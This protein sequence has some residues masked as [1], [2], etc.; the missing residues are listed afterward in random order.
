MYSRVLIVGGDVPSP[1]LPALRRLLSAEADVALG[2]ASDGGY[3]AIACRRTHPAMFDGVAWSSGS[4]LRHTVEACQRAG[5]TVALG[6]PWF[7]IDTPED[8]ERAR[9]IGIL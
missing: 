7:D 5:L 9:E 6:D 1:P 4:E 8:L 2:P 3:Y